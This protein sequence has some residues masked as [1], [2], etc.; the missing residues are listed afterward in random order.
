MWSLGPF[1]ALVAPRG[2][3]KAK[4]KGG[5]KDGAA[6]ASALRLLLMFGKLREAGASSKLFS[7]LLSGIFSFWALWLLLYY[8]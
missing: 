1:G 5:A 2:C 4:E 6:D 3:L 8:H 7:R